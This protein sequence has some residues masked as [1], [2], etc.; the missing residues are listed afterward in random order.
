MRANYDV[1]IAGAGPA[2][3]AFACLASSL[4]LSVAVVEKEA[5]AVLAAPPPDGREIAL[6]HRSMQTL[7]NLGVW[8]RFATD[9]IA[10]IKRACVRN[11]ASADLLRLDT[12]RSGVE[13]LGYLVSNHVI[14]RELYRQVRQTTGIDLLSGTG[15]TGVE[16]AGPHAALSLPTGARLTARLIVAADSRFSQLRRSAGIGAE[17]RDFGRVCIVCRMTHEAAHDATAY[18]WFDTDQTLAVL[19]L[20]PNTSSIVLTLPSNGAAAVLSMTPEAFAQEVERRFR[21]QWGPMKLAGERTAYPLV[22][23]YAHAFHARRF[24]LVGDAAVGMHPVTAHGF[25]FGLRGAET[26]AGEMRKAKEAGGDFAAKAV[27][28]AYDTA[29]R[30][31]TYPLYAATNAMVGLYTVN[32]PLAHLARHA[33]LRIGNAL[34]PVRSFMVHKLTEYD[35][36][37][38]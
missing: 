36:M 16:L 12:A 8:G 19:P 29:H 6:T 13:A 35:A 3:L 27:L 22:A 37:P 32:G 30:R 38:S 31:A 21:G 28:Q 5:D 4:G 7:K 9:E 23:V 25:N 34:P 14:R 11:A 24:A 18:E 15:V 33:L 10:P 26:L 17:M 20:G 2:G 1:A